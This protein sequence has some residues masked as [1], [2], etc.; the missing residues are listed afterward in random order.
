MKM[1]GRLAVCSLLAAA[2]PLALAV[3]PTEAIAP[4]RP[5]AFDTSPVDRGGVIEAVDRDK[6]AIVI[7]GV[8]YAI[9]L[10][11]VPIH[12]PSN[13]VSGQWSDLK[14]GMQVRFSSV[15]D[16]ARRQQQVREIWVTGLGGRS[17]R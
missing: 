8:S 6:R 13:K 1:L 5:S 10:G 9:P 15:K 7:E 3:R 16:E 17:P 11:S 12:W 4:G 2:A 14:A